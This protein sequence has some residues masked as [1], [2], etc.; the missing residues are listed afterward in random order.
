M[1]ILE[2]IEKGRQ[3]DGSRSIADKIIKRLHDLE[4]SVESNQGRW[5]WELL[6]NAK[7][8]I[9]DNGR[10]VKIKIE[11]FEDKVCFKHNGIYFTE[12]DIRGLI[13]QISSKELEEGETRRKT[14]RFGTGFLT[15][16]L[17]SK[18]VDVNGIVQI[19]SGKFYSF[20][21]P[22]N[23]EGKTTSELVPMID[24]TWSQFHESTKEVDNY[25]ET[26]FNTSF[27]YP[28]N[29]QTKKDIAR[30]GIEE[31]ENLIHYVLVFVP[32]IESVEIFYSE[33][34]KKTIFTNT[35]DDSIENV[36]NILKQHNGKDETIYVL[37][38]KEGNISVAS[39]ISKFESSFEVNE[40]ENVPKLFCDFPLIGSE[41]FHFPVIINCFD[42]TPLSERNGVWLK[43]KD[44]KEEIRRN[45]DIIEKAAQLY[46]VL[47]SI[48][49]E[50]KYHNLFNLVNTKMP[51]VDD[52]YFDTQ[53]YKEFIQDPIRDIIK[54]SPFVETEDGERANVGDVFFPDRDA[55]KEDR[56]KIWEYSYA[57][58]VN[59][60]PKKDHIHSW[61]NI[62]WADLN[63]CDIPD[64][65]KDFSNNTTISE[66]KNKLEK[67]EDDTINWLNSFIEFILKIDDS[68]SLFN[69][70]SIIPNQ[71]GDFKTRK[72]VAND[73]ILETTEPEGIDLKSILN[74]LG[75]NWYSNL[76]DKR[77]KYDDC[78]ET[79]DTHKIA[80]K[81]TSAFENPE[82]RNE[83]YKNAIR[84]ISEWFDR[85]E[86]EG[87]KYFDNLYRNRAKLLHDTITDKDSLYKIMK[88]KTPLD[89]V[90]EI[91]IGIENDPEILEIIRRRQREIKER[92]ENTLIG[93]QIEAIL[94]EALQDEGL[95]VESVWVGRDLVISLKN[96]SL[97]YDIEVKS[98]I[99][100][101]YVSMTPTQAK[102][103]A[104]ENQ[105]HYS[106]CVVHKDGST[107]NKDYVRNKSRFVIN[108]GLLLKSKVIEVEKL[109]D[110]KNNLCYS[111][112]E[113]NFLIEND[114]D[115]RYG[116]SNSIWGVGIK[117]DKFVEMIKA[118]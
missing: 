17:L 58:K 48:V 83:N 106:L 12:K 54:D 66:L 52:R 69:N 16:H 82:N 56:L 30:I 6:Q 104:F 81:I 70:N 26:D 115:Y 99:N 91:A 42:F 62:I 38:I 43:G 59:T 89:Q 20:S 90:A 114:L 118:L 80:N 79:W 53:W 11:L 4:L 9:I 98:T 77:I 76:K 96:D 40:F 111:N 86:E 23:R 65:V 112:E 93:E 37:N 109:I 33:N 100:T 51:Q 21:F 44:E 27:S 64:L 25:V 46:K 57:L 55:N 117:I 95:T 87:K 110:N 7:D 88:S 84:M 14:G 50:R 67:E 63:K 35:Y 24:R 15:T 1:P 73:I 105:E 60:L 113:I 18:E 36:A 94:K 29:S 97:H 49:T 101:S 32:E 10:K 13:N 92:N 71:E 28:L 47:S 78:Y 103:A 116:V 108:I 72:I 19:Q 85:N 61:G 75:I 8:S 45:K 107:I 68:I 3:E 22:L 2:S 34:E 39:E 41:K 74:E 102:T 5:I 31:F